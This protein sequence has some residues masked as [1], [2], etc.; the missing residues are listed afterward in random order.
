MLSCL[1]SKQLAALCPLGENLLKGLAGISRESETPPISESETP[2]ISPV[3]ESQGTGVWCLWALNGVLCLWA[4]VS[5][6]STRLSLVS[7]VSCLWTRLSRVSL[8][9][10]VS[11]VGHIFCPSPPPRCCLRKFTAVVHCVSK[12]RRE[13]ERERES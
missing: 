10:I 3:P 11:S 4:L 1:L 5:C 6:L 9:S 7:L 8:V 2:P 12:K 13:R